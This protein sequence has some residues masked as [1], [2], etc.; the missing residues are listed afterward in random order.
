VRE[1]EALHN[2]E[3]ANETLCDTNAFYNGTNVQ[4]ITNDCVSDDCT[5]V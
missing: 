4:P 1:S 3:R 2:W 5:N